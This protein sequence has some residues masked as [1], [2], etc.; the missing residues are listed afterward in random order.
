MPYIS[1]V[2]YTFC[3]YFFFDFDY[4]QR[5]IQ[6]I[7]LSLSKMMH[8][9]LNNQENPDIVNYLNYYDKIQKKV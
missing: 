2:F 6:W 5:Y 4:F 7:N 8:I 1:L 3:S 9:R